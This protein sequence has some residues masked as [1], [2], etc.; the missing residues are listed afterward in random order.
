M[1]FWKELD[2]SDSKKTSVITSGS[3]ERETVS[4]WRTVFF[5]FFMNSEI[6]LYHTIMVDAS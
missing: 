3:G 4:Q 1:T 6:I 5:F 2:Y